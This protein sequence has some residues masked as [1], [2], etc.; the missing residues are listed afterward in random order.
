MRFTDGT[1]IYTTNTGITTSAVY[2]TLNCTTLRWVKAR[3][4][5]A[6]DNSIYNVTSGTPPAALFSHANTDWE[7]VDFA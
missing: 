2:N 4:M 3:W 1:D 6:Q 5:A 7:W